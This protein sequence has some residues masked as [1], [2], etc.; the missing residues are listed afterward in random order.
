MRSMTRTI[1][2]PAL[3]AALGLMGL[4]SSPPALAGSLNKC[5]EARV[6]AHNTV[7]DKYQPLLSALDDRIA[8]A[9]ADGSDP[10]KL[11]YVDKDEQI[12]S[13]DAIALRKDLQK[14]EEMDAGRADRYAAT[15]CR[16]D[17]QPI[18]AIVNTADSIATRGIA[19]VLPKHMANIDLSHTPFRF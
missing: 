4:T 6:S 18:Q 13:V 15:T 11:P 19:T 3:T 17:D 16:D 14:E 9:N 5:D 12:R 2:P 10:A 8:R 7:M 1:V